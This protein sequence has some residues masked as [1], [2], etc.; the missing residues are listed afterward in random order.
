[1]MQRVRHN[2]EKDKRKNYSSGEGRRYTSEA[3][4][5]FPTDE[6]STYPEDHVKV[7]ARTSRESEEGGEWGR[8]QKTEHILEQV[9]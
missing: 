9:T 3:R 7:R 5:G 8:E 6:A 4:V 2:V 1:M